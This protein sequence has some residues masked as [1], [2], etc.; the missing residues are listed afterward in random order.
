MTIQKQ[1]ID[2]VNTGVKHIKQKQ[3]GGVATQEQKDNYLLE[4]IVTGEIDKVDR[5]LVAGANAN[6]K[7]E[8][9]NPA[10]IVAV[11]WSSGNTE[12]I[13]LLLGKGADVNAK[14]SRFGATVLAFASSDGHT[15]IVRLL[16]ENG[17]DINAKDNVNGYT[18]LIEA[19]FNN[20][21][22][23]VRLLLGNGADINAKDVRGATALMMATIKD[24]IEIVRLLLEYGADVNM[25]DNHN[26]TAIMLASMRRNDEIV[27]LLTPNMYQT[28][29]CMSL[30]EYNR[31]DIKEGNEE[32]HDP[33]SLETL[34]RK[35]AVKLEGQ[36]KVCYNRKTLKS[37]FKNSKTNPLTREPVS[38]IWIRSNLGDQPCEEPPTTGGKARRK[39]IK[40]RKTKTKTK[41]KRSSKPNKKITRKNKRQ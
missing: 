11:A 25:V 27:E 17:A 20:N 36:P 9:G 3:R 37:W 29:K 41:T 21:I 19:T 13:K 4:A 5:V 7:D 10:L 15:E 38:D 40:K 16:L 6:V 2:R 24:N 28:P 12:I 34:K 39:P 22:E 31:C 1:Q 32:P 26:Y 8:Q 18:A 14:E 35:D 23:V 30:E 33:I